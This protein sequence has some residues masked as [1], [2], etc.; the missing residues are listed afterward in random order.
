[1]KKI[2]VKTKGMALLAAGVTLFSVA[3]VGADH[4]V[5]Y[6]RKAH[7]IRQEAIRV[8]ALNFQ[9][10]MAA[11]KL[12]RKLAGKPIVNALPM[13]DA[14]PMV[15]QIIN[16]SAVAYGVEISNIQVQSK[17]NFGAQ[18]NSLGVPV[19]SLGT[20]TPMFRGVLHQM[21]LVKGQWKTL[22]GLENWL[23]V[24]ESTHAAI[25]KITI[26]SHYVTADVEIFG[27]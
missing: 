21:V 4:G 27:A 22:R 10:M 20:N 1:M 5:K 7:G 16:R 23:H 9:A 11:D 6:A 15:V 18:Y 13:G 14:V 19:A 8:R 25:S 2:S 12:E 3:I 24:V 26:K 17:K